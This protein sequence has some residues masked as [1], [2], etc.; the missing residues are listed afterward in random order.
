MWVRAAKPGDFVE[1]KVGA[2][3]A[4]KFKVVVYATRSWDYGIVQFSVNGQK[5]G[6]EIDLCSGKR[7]VQATGPIDL[8]A[9]DSKDGAFQLR[10]ELVGG[11]PKSE[12][13]RSFFGLD[14]IVLE[15]VK[16]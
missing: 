13:T 8:G 11:N 9:F 16:E 12:G 2:P 1:L 15:P 14:C 4:G 7:E 6:K 3:A 10:C 5:A